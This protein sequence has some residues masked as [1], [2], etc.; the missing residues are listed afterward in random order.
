ML[1]RLLQKSIARPE[2]FAITWPLSFGDVRVYSF[3]FNLWGGDNRPLDQRLAEPRVLDVG[4][5]EF[6]PPSDDDDL[7][8]VSTTHLTVEEE[9]YLGNP[10][11]T[12]LV[13][14]LMG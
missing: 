6:D 11:R 12:R 1:Y 4:W 5:T 10:G 8:A 2:D 9:R 14:C 7:K 3:A 13:T